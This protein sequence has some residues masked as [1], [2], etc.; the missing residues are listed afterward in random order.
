MILRV[1]MAN[2]RKQISVELPVDI[3]P[4]N[5]HP[6]QIIAVSQVYIQTDI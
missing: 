5:I 2:I 4:E 3:K 1:N 6:E